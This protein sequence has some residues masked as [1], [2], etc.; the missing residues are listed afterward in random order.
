MSSRKN[1]DRN[2]DGSNRNLDGRRLRTVD[3]AK[4]LA[5]YLATKPEM[6]K[7]ER[8]EKRKR[9]EAVVEAAERK[10]EEIRS[11]RGGNGSGRLDAKYVESKEEAERLTR[12]AMLESMR[13]DNVEPARTGS[14]SS[15]DRKDNED[16]RTGSSEGSSASP[17]PAVQAKTAPIFFGWDDDELSEDDED[18]SVEEPVTPGEGLPAISGKG[19]AKA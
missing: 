19:K 16:D 15:E 9:W 3:E 11:G 17:G 8:D 13:E 4:K 2:A 10:E 7:R 12:E 14:E 18:E 5:D 6:E 1:R